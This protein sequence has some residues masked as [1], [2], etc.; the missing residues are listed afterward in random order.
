MPVAQAADQEASEGAKDS[1]KPEPAKPKHLGP[2]DEYNRGVPRT[3][4]E[5]FLKYTSDGNFK[6]AANFLDMRNLPRS[7]RN[8][9]GSE[10]A[11]Q[12]KIV[13]DRALW[14]NL[15]EVSNA[16][17][18]YSDDGLPSYRESIGRIKTRDKT[19]D[20]FLQHVPRKEDGVFIW[21]FSNRTVAEI[22]SL[23]DEFGYSPMEERLSE[24]FPDIIFLGWHAWQWVM[25]LIYLVLA[26]ILAFTTT[27]LM[28]RVAHTKDTE[29]GHM[30]ARFFSRPLRFF[31]WV[32]LG[33]VG[34]RVIGPSTTL[35][36]AVKAATLITFV[37]TWLVLRI[38][39]LAF[40][41]WTE[42]LLKAGSESATVLLRPVKTMSKIVIVLFG[43]MIWLDN[44]GFNITTLLAGLGVGGFAVALAAQDTLKNFIGSILILLDKPYMIGERILVKGHDGVVE[45]IG[46]RSTRIREL[47]GHQTIIP[48]DEMSR[49]NIEN[50]GRRP[51]IRRSTTISIAYDTPLEKVE[52]AVGIIKGILDNHEGINPNFP[53]RVF[54]KEFAPTSL[55]IKMLY[56]YEPPKYWD[57][58]A[59]NERVNV[60]IMEEFEKEGIK[61]AL[62]ITEARLNVGDEKPLVDILGGDVDPEVKD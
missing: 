60:Q 34:V 26:F 57:F 62:P 39:D 54:F 43:A 30:S 16:P 61:L 4:V 21:K 38:T 3:S 19:V 12:L 28:A 6:Q 36:A 31:L 32:V 44:L 33:S 17:K 52:K 15:D 7:V 1:A 9:D 48:N 13:L 24:I 55:A 8:I 46:L 29:M 14:I 10:L 5:G 11:L 45:E 27:W 23:Y 56:W 49:L 58:V 41:W 47:N 25:L 53:P 2:V 18:G 59:F 35:Q 22:P 51:H 37:S 42:R 20:I 40:E 50:V